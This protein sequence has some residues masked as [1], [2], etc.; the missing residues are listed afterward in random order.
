[1]QER[2][3]EQLG[4]SKYRSDDVTRPRRLELPH[5]AVIWACADGK[6]GN[7]HWIVVWNDQLN[8]SDL[9]KRSTN[10]EPG[11]R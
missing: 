4:R 6:R 1:M 8:F 3:E 9:L 5:A 11:N 2:E 7:R 10:P